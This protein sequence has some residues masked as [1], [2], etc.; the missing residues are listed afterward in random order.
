MDS[1]LP[2]AVLL[3]LDNTILA[4]SAPNEDAWRKVYASFA[5]RIGGLEVER[6]LTAIGEV[7][8]WYWSDNERHL[9]GRLNPVDSRREIVSLAFAK[10]SINSPAVAHELADSFS[11]ER[12]KA[13]VPYPQAIETLEDFRNRGSRLAL[14]TNGSSE[15]QRSKIERFNLAPFF[16]CIIVEGEFGFGKPDEN[17][18]LY[19]LQQLN[20]TAREAWMVG[21]DLERDIAGAQSAGIF[22]VWIDWRDEGLPESTSIRP[23][24]IIRTLS[25]LL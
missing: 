12:E 4:T 9:H 3:D 19:A 8:D 5:S 25:E 6:L 22:A 13:I 2:K 10:L 1:S 15:L 17:V 20:V 21:D 16:D 14:L 23:D 18:F 24:R 11:V 7:S